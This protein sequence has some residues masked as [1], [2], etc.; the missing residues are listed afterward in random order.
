MGHC[1]CRNGSDIDRRAV[2]ALHLRHELRLRKQVVR[3]LQAIEQGHT[4]RTRK[5][6]VAWDGT[7]RA[8]II[9]SKSSS[10]S[11]SPHAARAFFRARSCTTH[12]A[13]VDDDLQ[14]T[15][16]H[17]FNPQPMPP[18]RALYFDSSHTR[19]LAATCSSLRHR[20]M[21]PPRPLQ[22][23]SSAAPSN[24]CMRAHHTHGGLEHCCCCSVACK[25]PR[26][27]AKAVGGVWTNRGSEAGGGG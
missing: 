14:Y 24:E 2:R 25:Q 17:L 26:V 21:L 27:A 1:A 8:A 19:C 5:N 18:P 12:H 3:R 20:H 15:H 4:M 22:Q 13:S 9:S 16:P 6:C 10:I 23:P 11:S 7:L